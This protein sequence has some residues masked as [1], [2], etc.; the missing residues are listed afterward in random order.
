MSRPKRQHYVPKLLLRRFAVDPKA[1]KP[2]VWVSR[3]GKQISLQDT[4]NV[5]VVQGLNDLP[6]DNLE[7]EF[8]QQVE[9]PLTPAIDD[10]LSDPTEENARRVFHT[11]VPNLVIRGTF[12]RSLFETS[13]QYFSD[14]LLAENPDLLMPG[15]LQDI[16]HSAELG[17]PLT[18]QEQRQDAAK[19]CGLDLSLR[20]F[21]DLFRGIATGYGVMEDRKKMNALWALAVRDVSRRSFRSVAG[22]TS[23]GKPEPH[24]ELAFT[25]EDV[26][27]PEFCVFARY[28][29][30]WLPFLSVIEPP[31]AM[32][33]PI[34]PRELLVSRHDQTCEIPTPAL[35]NE[36]SRT[37]TRE[38]LVARCK[39]SLPVLNDSEPPSVCQTPIWKDLIEP[40]IGELCKHAGSKARESH[41]DVIQ[42][43][44]QAMD[45]GLSSPAEDSG[46]SVDPD[47]Q[48]RRAIAKSRAE[49]LRLQGELREAKI[50]QEKQW[51]ARLRDEPESKG[52]ADSRRLDDGIPTRNT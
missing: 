21:S 44:T 2:K 50:K 41:A 23:S 20:C 38:W 26:I 12:I 52:T 29:A 28:Q 5:G 7:L 35:L 14:R 45:A 31:S 11:L 42:Q 3:R 33:V 36:V 30:G 18:T 25:A 13:F 34:G 49:T 24:Y 39:D 37:F 16:Q 8:S 46:E 51:S 32:I 22:E 17:G 9:T 6:L 43:F 1:K 40:L 19:K 15:S 4:T 48:F 27:Q 10:L 47:E